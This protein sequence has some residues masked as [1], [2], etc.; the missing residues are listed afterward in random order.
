MQLRRHSRSLCTTLLA[1]ASVVALSACGGSSSSSSTSS[2]GGGG[3]SSTTSGGSSGGTI[4]VVAGTAPDSLDPG[5]GY[6]TQAAEAD[7]LAYTGLTTYAHAGGAGRRS[8]DPGPGDRAADRQRRRQDVHRDAAQGP[9]VLERQAGQGERLHVHDR[10]RAE[11]PVGRLRPVLRR[12][13]RRRQR[14]RGRQGEDDLR[15]HDRRRDRQDHD[16]SDR[17]RTARST[18]CSRS[19]PR[20]SSRPA[21]R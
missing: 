18:T 21:R 14:L 2:S 8:G 5:F 10:A 11:D 17:A 13:D 4:T 12:H 9:R 3:G 6:T 15:H 20:A 7:W 16:P 19:R 1:L